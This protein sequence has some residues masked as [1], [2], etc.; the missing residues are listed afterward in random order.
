MVDKR[1][2]RECASEFAIKRE[3]QLFCSTRCRVRHNR[4]NSHCFYC[5]DH[6]TDRDHVHPVSVRGAGLRFFGNVEHVRACGECNIWLSDRIFDHPADRAE[7]VARKI[8]RKYSLDV[9]VVR[10]DEEELSEL[11]VGLRRRVK[12]LLELR[13]QGEERR[14]YAEAVAFVLRL[15]VM[16]FSKPTLDD[17]E[18]YNWPSRTTRNRNH[19]GTKLTM[20]IADDIRNDR[21]KGV[22]L[23]DLA[24]KYDISV[25]H[26]YQITKGNAWA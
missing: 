25:S 3:W 4:R 13:R 2:C 5:G 6:A 14:L 7:F 23:K 18:N 8:T 26:A 15:D 22:L 16:E 9:P 21:S 12:K 17:P 10:W 11:G 24:K 20:Q 19:R 1:L